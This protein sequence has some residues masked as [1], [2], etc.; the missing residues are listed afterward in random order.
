MIVPFSL[1]QVFKVAADDCY[2]PFRPVLPAAV[3]PEFVKFWA[4]D[5]ISAMRLLFEDLRFT[6]IGR[7]L[8]RVAKFA[9]FLF[10]YVKAVYDDESRD[11]KEYFPDEGILR[12]SRF[13]HAGVVVVF[14]AFNGPQ[15]AEI[16]AQLFRLRREQMLLK[17]LSRYPQ[18][19]I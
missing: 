8:R 1:C 19:F 13:L 15:H 17:H 12:P 2:W 5:E 9:S 16:K 7:E 14:S 4:A 18:V 6:L 3:D 11:L 10:P